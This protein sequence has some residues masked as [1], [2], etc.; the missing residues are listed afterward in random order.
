MVKQPP[1]DVTKKRIENKVNN[2]I[3][4]SDV[5][6]NRKKLGGKLGKRLIKQEEQ[7]KSVTQG[8]EI[9]KKKYKRFDEWCERTEEVVNYKGRK[10]IKIRRAAVVDGNDR[11]KIV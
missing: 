10:D 8:K 4:L 5:L 2:I 11:N 6:A 3:E 7:E 1:E 9:R